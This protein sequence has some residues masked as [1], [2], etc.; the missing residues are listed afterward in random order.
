[1]SSELLYLIIALAALIA[2]DLT[3]I[4]FGKDSRGPSDPRRDWS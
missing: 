1:M 3:A 4:R 2:L